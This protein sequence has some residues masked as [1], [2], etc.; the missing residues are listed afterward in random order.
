[1]KG[2][3]NLFYKEKLRDLGFCSLG[4][5]KAMGGPQCSLTVLEESLQA[6]GR[7]GFYTV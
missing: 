2:L 6:G 4:E 7:Q 5:K 1:M 3:E